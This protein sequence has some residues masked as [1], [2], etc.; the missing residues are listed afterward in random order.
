M[1]EQVITE[2]T[3]DALPA[4]RGVAI[5]EAALSSA[6]EANDKLVISIT[7]V[8]GSLDRQGASAAGS[9]GAID[10]YSDALKRASDAAT[11]GSSSVID[12]AGNVLTL[13]GHLKLAALAAYALSPAFREVVNLALPTVFAAI[14]VT[15]TAAGGA[16]V[17]VLGPALAFV[18]RLTLPLLAIV[19]A[20]EAINYVVKTGSDLLDKY[21]NAQRQLYAPTVDADLEKLTKF[22]QD[23][24]SADQVQYATDLGTRLATAK[25]TISDFWHTQIDVTNVALGLQ[26]VWVNI[27]EVIASAARKMDALINSTPSWAI[28]FAS[29]VAKGVGSIVGVS[30]PASYGPAAEVTAPTEQSAEDIRQAG[31]NRLK[32]AMGGQGTFAGRFSQDITDLADTSKKAVAAADDVRDAW[33]RAI[34][35]IEKHTLSLQ[36]DTLTMG[37]SAGATA[38]LKAE[39]QLLEAAK[40]SD[41]G[42]TDKDISAYVALRAQGVSVD[43]ALSKLNINMHEQRAEFDR[44]V[45]GATKAAD[46]YAKMKVAGD[47]KFSQG[48][49]G[50]T[51]QDVA[52]A[53]KLKNVYGDDIP[54]A[55]A[56]TEAAQLRVI[57]NIK[58]AQTYAT[59]FATTFVQGMIDGKSGMEALASASKSLGKTL[60]DAGISNII[61]DPSNFTGYIEAAIGVVAQLVSTTSKKGLSSAEQA[62]ISDQ[63]T[64][65]ARALSATESNYDTS[66]YA[67]E[68]AKNEMTAQQDRAEEAAKGNTALTELETALAGERYS[69]NLKWANSAIAVLS[70]VTDSTVVARVNA[71]KDAYTT[72]TSS[73]TAL[74][75]SAA[76]VAN[77]VGAQYTAAL[78]KLRT[79]T[80]AGITA[81]DNTAKGKSYLNDLT[82]LETT[83]AGQRSDAVALADGNATLLQ[84]YLDQINT[85]FGDAAQKIVDDSSLTG[86]A[87]N[88]LITL[89]PDLTGVVKESAAAAL[90]AASAMDAFKKSMQSYL[91]SLL[92]G[93]N[94]PLSGQDKLGAAQS[95]FD[96]QYAL[97]A[98]GNS[99]AMSSLSSYSDNVLTAARDLY[100]SS[101]SY[102]T[103]FTAITNQLTAISG[104]VM[105]RQGGGMIGYDAGGVVG[106]GRFGMDSVFAMNTLGKTIML[107]GGEGIL[108][109]G[110]TRSIGG[111]PAVDFMNRTGS[112]PANDNSANF[113]NL[114]STFLRGLGAA[115][116][117]QIDALREENAALRMEVRA[118][119]AAIK[120]KPPEVRGTRMYG[121]R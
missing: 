114:G 68:L 76:S 25:Q 104:A 111:A 6:Q 46:A 17:G 44:V 65:N 87:F 61:K 98:A 83:V 82:D 40:T 58:T 92:V 85:Y 47:I 74:G 106:N 45:E 103:I 117:A 97:A 86:D 119:A 90:A 70:T 78:E 107:A 8:G 11:Q 79:D 13:V 62:T 24:I 93:S 3:V 7:G 10:Q 49:L 105:G 81:L 59:S 84:T 26:A 12:A 22:Q 60:T 18:S 110:A 14:G 66:T 41:L 108:N 29:G 75:W 9:R 102:A 72:L 35:S 101:A 99:D 91:D 120:A 30:A 100:A 95:A 20:W 31:L 113:E 77:Y 51:D 121:G 73:L 1:P 33:D 42:I 38:G 118:V 4:Q 80:V 56:S 64:Y 55:L 32:F 112:L 115:T 48:T 89:F 5:Y 21:A 116:M 43:D 52:I 23:T 88:E 36:A 54:T 16:I 27:V 2:L 37:Q 53:T 94:S 39:F 96:R 63:N 28:S 50:L 109:A 69:I 57:D 71:I 19:A 67:G 34:T 15:A